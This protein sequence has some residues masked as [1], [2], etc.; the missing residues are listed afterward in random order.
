MNVVIFGASGMVG[1]GALL[2][3]LADERV[4]SV[5]VIGRSRCGVQ[6]QKLREIL[7]ADF[8]DVSPI[9]SSFADRDACFFCLGVSSVGMTEEAYRHVT[10]DLT[11]TVARAMV[12]VN[13]HLTFCYIS[14]TGT[15]S[16]GQGRVMWARVK[17]ETENALLAMPFKAAY[18]FRPAFIQP[19]KGVRTKTRLYRVFYALAAPLYPI[20][21]RL[22][23]RLVTT[24][25]HV[26][27]ALIQVAAAGY[28][29]RILETEDINRV[30]G[31]T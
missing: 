29:S 14:G 7:H 3:C 18:M 24:T 10:L 25:E 22:F 5:L 30:A 15:D 17:G 31:A 13:S 19:L 27:R 26:G 20:L 23:P 16:T 1:S 2:E 21:R 11:V 28:P 6:H 8:F 12:A 4:T 9:Q